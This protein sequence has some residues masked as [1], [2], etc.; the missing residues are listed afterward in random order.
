MERRFWP[1]E[2]R[3]ER[4]EGKATKIGGYAARFNSESVDLG[5]FSERIAPGAFAA[6]LA[7]GADV[8]ALLNH[9]P[10]VVLG[11]SKSG[12][13]RL[14]E[15][16]N[17]LAFDLDLPDTSAGRDLAV[18]VERRD[19]AEMS[20]GFSVQKGGDTWSKVGDRWL[21]TLLSVDLYD[22]SPVAFAAYPQ[23]EVGLR[24][25]G[26]SSEA[27][28][29]LAVAKVEEEARERRLRLLEKV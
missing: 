8:R 27:L 4:A 5:G 28:A 19:I 16:G 22:V 3:V 7:K 23:T 13:L 12:T 21:R 18:S 17:G 26:V 11:R 14:A 25:A 9:N 1:G 24:A 15:D 2:I 29:G 6:A 20:F 10:D